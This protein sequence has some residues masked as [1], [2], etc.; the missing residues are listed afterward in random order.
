[1]RAPDRVAAEAV[2]DRVKAHTVEE[3]VKAEADATARKATEEA[4]E[5]EA[6]VAAGARWAQ[7]HL[8]EVVVV[9]VVVVRVV[10]VRVAAQEEEVV[11]QR[12]AEVRAPCRAGGRGCPGRGS[13]LPPPCAGGCPRWSGRLSAEA[14]GSREPAQLAASVDAASSAW[15]SSASLLHET[16][17]AS[18]TFGGVEQSGRHLRTLP[19]LCSTQRVFRTQ[20]ETALTCAPSWRWW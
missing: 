7:H 19:R 3:R 8:V 17:R 10:A 18:V 5:A 9:R 1:M 11:V 2:E 20:L 16:L 15:S 4:A 12:V 13:P 14:P 6:E